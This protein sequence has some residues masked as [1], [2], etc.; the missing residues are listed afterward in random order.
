MGDLNLNPRENND[1]LRL[2]QLCQNGQLEILLQ[3]PTIK[4]YNQP[5]HIL[6]DKSLKGKIFVTS[7][8]NFISDHKTIV[9][10]VGLGDNTLLKNIEVRK[11][12]SNKYTKDENVKE[13]SESQSFHPYSKKM[14]K[15]KSVFGNNLSDIVTLD[16]SC[17]EDTEWLNGDV[18]NAYSHIIN[19]QFK[20]S[21]FIFSTYFYQSLVNRGVDDMHRWTRNVNI[22]EKKYVFFPIHE[23]SHWYLILLNNI[24]KALYILDPYVPLTHLKFKKLHEKEFI[25]ASEKKSNIGFEHEKRLHKILH[26]YILMHHQ[27]PP[28]IVYTASVNDNIPK[29]TNDYDCGV[30]LLAFMKYTVLE[31]NF[32]FDTN[33]MS[34]FRAIFKDEILNS[35]IE[36]NI[37]MGNQTFNFTNPQS[38]ESNHTT[39]VNSSP[40]GDKPPQ[41][42]TVIQQCAG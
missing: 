19:Q 2:A 27:C 33:D 16:L 18:I 4:S 20:E 17:L 5:D 13:T 37:S 29:Q 9:A 42:E 8:F 23:N 40:V 12:Y 38:E 21:A 31:A 36:C 32:D 7:F 35:K 30:F 1:Q 3:E 10:R 11:V 34:S 24:H 41:F 15:E 26:E 25:K 28:N 22:F 39:K 6:G 14:K